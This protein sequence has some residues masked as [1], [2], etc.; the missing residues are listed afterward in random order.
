MRTKQA[1]VICSAITGVNALVSLAFSL[2]MVA[3][4]R[5]GDAGA[6]YALARTGP[7]AVAAIV[8]LVVRSRIGV[9]ML[10]S[11][12]SLVQVCDA[13][14]GWHIGDATKTIGPLMLAVLTAWSVFALARSAD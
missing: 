13:W 9:I 5:A 12:L 14:V 11:L 1:L 2:A 7:L 3:G 4:Q 8:V 6:L 10:G